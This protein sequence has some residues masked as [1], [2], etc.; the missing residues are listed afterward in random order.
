MLPHYANDIALSF[1]VARLA[2]ISHLKESLNVNWLLIWISILID[3][4][5]AFN[6]PVT[7]LN[8]DLLDSEHMIF[9]IVEINIFINLF[10]IILPS[11]FIV[12]QLVNVTIY[13][14][15]RLSIRC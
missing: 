4:F 10:N 13:F 9:I 7:L 2:R 3:P 6:R 14:I 5:I 11:L 8:F 1:L 12:F 15:R